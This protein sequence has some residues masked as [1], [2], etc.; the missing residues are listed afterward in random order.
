VAT[1]R[2]EANAIYDNGTTLQRLR[3]PQGVVGAQVVRQRETRD[4]GESAAVE[5]RRTYR[6]E[7]FAMSRGSGLFSA[8]TEDMPHG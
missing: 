5:A 7:I 1:V 3:W 6:A 4:R 8:L 2:P